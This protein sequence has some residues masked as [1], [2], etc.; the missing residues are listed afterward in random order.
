[1]SQPLIL[2]SHSVVIIEELTWGA[3]N[4]SAISKQPAFALSTRLIQLLINK[5]SLLILTQL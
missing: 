2:I 1:M 4:K 5:S 3:I